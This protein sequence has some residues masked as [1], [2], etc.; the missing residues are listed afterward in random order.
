LR[1]AALCTAIVVAAYGLTQATGLAWAALVLYEATLV[2]LSGQLEAGQ[3]LW[4]RLAAR[5]LLSSCAGLVP[6][7]CAQMEVRFSDE[8]F[9]AGLQAILL[10][11]VWFAL[12]SGYAWIPRKS[13]RDAL[14]PRVRGIALVLVSVALVVI[15]WA[16][17]AQ[18]Q[19]S[20]YSSPGSDNEW[21]TATQPFRVQPIAGETQT[22]DGIVVHARL[23]DRVRQNPNKGTCEY[24]MLALATGD[25]AWAAAFHDKLLCEAHEGAY[26]EPAHSV[27]IGQYLAAQRLYYYARVREAFPGLFSPDELRLLQQWYLD[28]NERARTVEWVD[29]L[30]SA[31]F[32]MWPEGFYENQENGAGLVAL[33]EAQSIARGEQSAV[34][35]DYLARN[36]RGWEARFRNTDDAV[37]YQGEWITNALFQLSYTGRYDPQKQANSFEWLLLQSV[38]DGYSLQYNHPIAV[39]MASTLYL[40]ATLL[41]DERYVWLAGRAVDKAE[42]TGEYLYA[43]PGIEHPVALVGCSPEVGSALL[44]G[45]SGLPNQVGP[46]A[47]D[48]VVFRDGWSSDAAYL[49]LNLRF[50]GWHRYKGTNAIILFYQGNPLIVEELAGEPSVWLPV[51]RSLFRDKR[52]PRENLNGLLVPR[53]GLSAVLTTLTGLGSSW[54]QDPPHYARVEAFE[55]YPGLDYSRTVIDNWHGWRHSRE[56]YFYHQGPVVIIDE[57]VG[58]ARQRAAVTWQVLAHD[59]AH[60]AGRFL[61]GTTADPAEMV[62]LSSNGLQLLP[63]EL[64]LGAGHMR[65]T[66]DP[67]QEGRLELATIILTR[68]WVGAQVEM[69]STSGRIRIRKGADSIEV[70]LPKVP[71]D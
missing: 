25:R 56:I 60:P 6:V 22:Y 46:L 64:V 24:G 1:V 8:E 20:F 40:G 29:W 39:S 19:S 57:A 41:Q 67:G 28:I 17:L 50:T 71:N 65:I 14:A 43:Q 32:G 3:P 38:P 21:V 66:Y 70:C 2:A 5:T 9:Y 26:T 34:N 15:G 48:K 51:G 33:L 42:S 69:D 45:D 49:L 16:T 10:A 37:L 47:P 23:V 30:Y 59:Q 63:D 4:L 31:A 44:Y 7:A 12:A 18:Y 36:R 52:I 13:H 53:S 61:L 11:L 58:P 62:L 35:R 55:A 27:K 68:E 54:A